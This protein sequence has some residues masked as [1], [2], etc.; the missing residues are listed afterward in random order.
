MW[1]LLTSLEHHLWLPDSLINIIFK[2]NLIVLINIFDRQLFFISP[3][4]S[5][6]ILSDV[7]CLLDIDSFWDYDT[8]QLYP[9]QW[10]GAELADTA[11]L[12]SKAEKP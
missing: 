10:K 6:E 1:L 7:S 8:Y 11:P 5:N 4:K 3:N 12:S 9:Q 2:N